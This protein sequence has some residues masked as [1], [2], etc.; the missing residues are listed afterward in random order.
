[1]FLAGGPLL[2]ALIHAPL[3]KR[4]FEIIAR[5]KCTRAGAARGKPC[6]QV[7]LN[8]ISRIEMRENK[9]DA[10]AMPDVKLEITSRLLSHLN[11]CRPTKRSSFNRFTRPKH[12]HRHDKSFL[13]RVSF[14][15]TS[16][17]SLVLYYIYMYILWKGFFSQEYR[18]FRYI[19]NRTPAL[20]VNVRYRN[21]Y[22]EAL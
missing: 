21:F 13:S 17:Y 7:S 10:S 4:R 1:M 5:R 15:R 3:A 18:F 8:V 2:S 14:C 11:H 20:L 6:P 16:G 22:E 9:G 19:I 12:C